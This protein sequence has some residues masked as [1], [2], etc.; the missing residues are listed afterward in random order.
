MH[1][2]FTLLIIGG[3]ALMAFGASAAQRTDLAQFSLPWATEE[4]K[5]PPAPKTPPAP[6]AQP[7]PAPSAPS[8]APVK[9]APAETP[10]AQPAP[11]AVGAPA[12]SQEAKTP[13][14]AGP[15]WAVN[16]RSRAGEKGL[17][18]RMSQTVVAKNTRQRLTEVAF[19]V[20]PEAK[21]TEVLLQL[22]LGLYLPA[23]ASYQ[24]DGSAPQ[25][26]S[27][28]ACT[29]SGC[30]A[31]APVSPEILQALRNGK[32]LKIDFKDRAERPVTVPLSLEGFEAAY[33]K[34]E[35]P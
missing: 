10:K 5:K 6:K 20:G 28:R 13:E 32:V 22:P 31:R 30:Y 17:S 4:K 8:Q 2:L 16:C 34:I 23:G 9:T 26:L 35:S 19:L 29:R 1:R 3:P 14:S 12:A 21:T 7:A 18:C 11:P 15:G 27:I 33:A 24:V 25:R